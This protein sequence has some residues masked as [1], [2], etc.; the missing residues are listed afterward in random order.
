MVN[1]DWGADLR[2]R[3]QGTPYT[4][5]L[6]HPDN[7]MLAIA[8]LGRPIEVWNIE[9]G[10]RVKTLSKVTTDVRLLSF[11][12]NGKW[13]MIAPHDNSF[14]RM[15]TGVLVCDTENWCSVCCLNASWPVAFHPIDDLIAAFSVR[16]V[17]LFDYQS[18]ECLDMLIEGAARR[19]EIFHPIAFSPCGS[20]L[21][22]GDVR[23]SVWA[24]T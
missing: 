12:S 9:S 18:G 19:E 20:L 10:K 5:V 8:S 11:N 22:S 7:E 14:A 1:G 21:V 17:G 6:I 2:L 15:R 4:E 13:L 24:R 16:G 3:D 23:L